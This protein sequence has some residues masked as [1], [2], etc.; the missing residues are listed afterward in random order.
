MALLICSQHP[1]QGWSFFSPQALCTDRHQCLSSWES[2]NKNSWCAVAHVVAWI[3]SF[4]F[5]LLFHLLELWTY[6]FS[7]PPSFPSIHFLVLPLPPASAHG[8]VLIIC[9]AVDLGGCFLFS[10]APF[11]PPNLRKRTLPFLHR[12]HTGWLCQWCAVYVRACQEL[13]DKCLSS[14]ST[15]L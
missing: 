11:V 3:S 10:L 13:F 8:A 2:M 5:C 12:F 1:P 14:R 6:L 4:P 7:M 9:N 15:N